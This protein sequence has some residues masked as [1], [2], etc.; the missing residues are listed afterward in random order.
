MDVY[1]IN[2]GDSDASEILDGL[3]EAIDFAGARVYVLF[4]YHQS[5]IGKAELIARLGLLL[6]GGPDVGIIKVD[7]FLNTNFHGQHPS[8]TRNDFVVYRRFHDHIPFGGPNLILSGPLLSEFLD[9]FGESREH[10]MFRPH[11]A[12]FFA[13]RLFENWRLQ[14]SPPSLLIE[15]GGNLL[16]LEVQAYIVPAIRL[17]SEI[18]SDTRLMLLA[19]AGYNREVL[20]TRPIINA[21][22]AGR[23]LALT[24][25][26]VFARMHPEFPPAEDYRAINAHIRAKISHALLSLAP[27]SVVCVPHYADHSL[28]G[29]TE[30]LTLF[31]EDIFAT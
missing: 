3:V 19:E 26:V 28:T 12:K 11:V 9:K 15:I 23:Q 14:G 22:E 7:G 4:G 10:L 29:Y 30:H 8:R 21:L 20:K 24:F 18:Y 17:L 1:E 5:D 13:R 16:D 27:P 31:K 6:G 25:D 2:R